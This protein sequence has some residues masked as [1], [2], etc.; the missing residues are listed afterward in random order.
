[1][2]SNGIVFGYMSAICPE[3]EAKER[4]ALEKEQ[5]YSVV[6]YQYPSYKSLGHITIERFE[7]DEE[8]LTWRRDR[9]RTFA[10][11]MSRQVLIFNAFNWFDN[12]RT[13]FVAPDA[14]SKL[15]LKNMGDV[16]SESVAPIVRFNPHLT[17]GRGI[18]PHLFE[19]AKEFFADKPVN[20]SF[21]C[22]NIALRRFNSARRQFDVVERFYFGG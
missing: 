7:A 4:A 5:L 16:Y 22:T 8:L 3:G 12:S 14:K 19:K 2:N 9:L 20:I 1:M 21:N 13:I 18:A 15:W 11:E 6:N 10:S 17:V